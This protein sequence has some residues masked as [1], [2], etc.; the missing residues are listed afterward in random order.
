MRDDAVE[1]GD[2]PIR[3]GLVVPSAGSLEPPSQFGGQRLSDDGLAGSGNAH[4]DD[5][6]LTG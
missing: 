6:H 2:P 3:I 5:D 1:F 4:E